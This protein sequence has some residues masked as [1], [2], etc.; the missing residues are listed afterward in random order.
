MFSQKN[1]TC[2]NIRDFGW[3]NTSFK[4]TSKK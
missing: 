2:G 1:V 3:T 4:F